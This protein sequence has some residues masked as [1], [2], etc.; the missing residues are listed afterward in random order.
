MNKF[1]SVLDTLQFLLHL[2]KALLSGSRAQH[3]FLPKARFI[4]QMQL[5]H[6]WSENKAISG[7]LDLVLNLISPIYG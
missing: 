3:F 2:H 5:V 7:F 1:D 4:L 6:K